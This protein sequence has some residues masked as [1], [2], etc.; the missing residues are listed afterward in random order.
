MRGVIRP[1]G[2]REDE[3]IAIAGAGGENSQSAF[4]AEKFRA[5]GGLVA[6]NIAHL[7]ARP[8]GQ[9]RLVAAQFIRIFGEYR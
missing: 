3:T 2:L 8:L 5:A 6:P 9:A 1:G 7:I 4:L